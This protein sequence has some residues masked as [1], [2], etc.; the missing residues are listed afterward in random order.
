MTFNR[1]RLAQEWR[2]LREVDWQALE[3]RE[4]GGWPL[5]LKLLS[6]VLVLM[7]A[8]AAMYGLVVREH[9]AAL[10]DA[11]QQEEQLLTTFEQK[12]AEASYLPRVQ[13]QLATLDAKMLELRAM[14]PTSAEIP[15]LLDSIND[16]A[17]ENRLSIDTIR[18]NSTV[19]H[20]YYIE[21]PFDIQV[22]GGYHQIARFVADMAALSRVVTQHDF[23][24]AP[25]EGVSDT[26]R[27]SMLART[28]SYQKSVAEEQP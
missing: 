23:T 3:L 14:L 19:V 20:G 26:L 8:L 24:L 9:R 22:R 5:L 25:V 7:L 10:G 4:A 21:H 11:R 28:Y 13:Q 16:A 17:V 12:S 2:Q 6:C 18:L 1:E 27:L 15:S